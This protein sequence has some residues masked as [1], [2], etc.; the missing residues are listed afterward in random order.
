MLPNVPRIQRMRV[1]TQEL[2]SS[3][4]G[5][6]TEHVPKAGTMADVMAR[7][8]SGDELAVAQAR[9]MGPLW[10][11]LQRHAFDQD[12]VQQT[13]ARR[14]YKLRS[15]QSKAQKSSSTRQR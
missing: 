1:R 15:M 6:A 13:W 3:N 10:K 12:E 8:V 9:K 4:W 7:A 11:D 14:H 5:E 2:A